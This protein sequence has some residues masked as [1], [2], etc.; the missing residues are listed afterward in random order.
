MLHRGKEH[1]MRPER[2]FAIEFVTALVAAPAVIR[3]TL[4]EPRPLPVILPVFSFPQLPAR[5][6]VGEPPWVPQSVSPRLRREARITDE[7]IVARHRV[8]A[9]FVRVID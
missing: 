4:D 2:V 7:W 9:T 5:R 3:P 6:V 8:G 1:R